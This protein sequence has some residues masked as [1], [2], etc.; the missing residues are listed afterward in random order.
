MKKLILVFIFGIPLIGCVPKY[1]S[2]SPNNGVSLTIKNEGR[3]AM[4]NIYADARCT[5]LAN[6]ESLGS[7]GAMRVASMSDFQKTVYVTPN[8]E[9]TLYMEWYGP[10]SGECV[11]TATFIPQINTLYFAEYK[12]EQQN[13]KLEISSK[14]YDEPNFQPLTQSNVKYGN[15]HCAH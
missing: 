1:Q 4:T 10:I 14:K 3:A 11:Q 9:I 13:C 6:G 7:I 12:W 15:S 8:R 2:L 5:P